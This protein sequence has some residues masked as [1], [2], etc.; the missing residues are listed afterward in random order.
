LNWR[1][2]NIAE[3]SLVETEYLLM[4]SRDPGYL[5]PATLRSP[6]GEIREIAAMLNNLRAK[7]E[8]QAGL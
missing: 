5:N 8:D 1:F 3:G 2:L 6:L 4:L 7:V